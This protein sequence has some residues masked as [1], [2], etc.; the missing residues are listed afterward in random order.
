[1]ILQHGVIGACCF[2]AGFRI[3]MSVIIDVRNNRRIVGECV[4]L[5]IS[6]KVGFK[7]HEIGLLRWII[8]GPAQ[9]RRE[10]SKRIVAFHVSTV[11]MRGM[12]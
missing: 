5:Q 7:G 12:P 8:S 6:F 1:M 11:Q 3:I 2:S 9:N 10:I 4:V